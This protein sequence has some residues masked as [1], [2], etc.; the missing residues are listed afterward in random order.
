MVKTALKDIYLGGTTPT[1]LQNEV[2]TCGQIYYN[3][4]TQVIVNQSLNEFYTQ[5]LFNLTSW[6]P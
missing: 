5:N 1:A 3:K 6:G 2:S 4:D